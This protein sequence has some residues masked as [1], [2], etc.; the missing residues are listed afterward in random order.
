[1]DGGNLTNDQIVKLARAIA[2]TDLEAIALEYFKIDEA[3]IR[4]FRSDNR[5]DAQ[6]FNRSILMNWMHRNT[7]T[8]QV[9]AWLF[10]VAF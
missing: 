5:E 10:F 4:N 2:T 3:T 8:N 9:Q 6:A 1:M 7:G